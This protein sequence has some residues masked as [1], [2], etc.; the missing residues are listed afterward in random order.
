MCT[1]FYVDTDAD[2]IRDIVSDVQSSQL[3]DKFNIVRGK[4]EPE[5]DKAMVKIEGTGTVSVVIVE[6]K[7]TISDRLV[8]VDLS[9]MEKI[10]ETDLGDSVKMITMKLAHGTPAFKDVK[11]GAYYADAVAWAVENNVTTGT[12]TTTFSPSDTC[13]RGQVVTFL[14]RNATK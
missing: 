3:S 7:E 14:Y 12:S 2:E 6:D 13:T 5:N 4:L 11:P 9:E 1:R 8:R 10:G